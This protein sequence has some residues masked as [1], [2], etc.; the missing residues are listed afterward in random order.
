MGWHTRVCLSIQECRRGIL[1][2]ETCKICAAGTE[3][4][5]WLKAVWWVNSA[6]KG[7]FY[8]NI[9]SSFHSSTKSAHQQSMRWHRWWTHGP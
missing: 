1:L 4:H 3:S 5:G 7:H 6:G 2:S 9:L 8:V